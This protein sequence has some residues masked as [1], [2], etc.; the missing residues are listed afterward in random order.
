MFGHFNDLS[1]NLTIFSIVDS[2]YLVV[3]SSF[4]LVKILF[5]FA[6]C[7]DSFSYSLVTDTFFCISL[8]KFGSDILKMFRNVLNSD[9]TVL[10]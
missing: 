9:S 10:I 8:R 1:K 5:M 7:F 3:T 2:H 6:G 4:I